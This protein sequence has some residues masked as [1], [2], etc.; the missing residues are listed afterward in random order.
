LVGLGLGRLRTPLAFHLHISPLTSSGRRNRAS[1]ASQPEKRSRLH[2]ATA[3][4][5]TT[6]FREHVVA[7]DQKQNFYC[8]T[9]ILLTWNIWWVSNNA[10][11]WQMGF[12]RVFK[13][14]SPIS[15][16]KVWNTGNADI[17][18]G[19]FRS[20]AHCMFSDLKINLFYKIHLQAFNVISIVLYHSVPTFGK[21]LYSCPPSLL[22]RLI[23]QATS[24]DTSSMLLKHF[25][26]RGF[27]NF[28]NKSKSGGLRS[29]P[30]SRERLPIYHSY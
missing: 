22:M 13:G 17:Y 30:R 26:R 29:C 20:S 5:Q 1:W 19:H 14:L 10:S 12:N 7:L 16:F 11:R 9:L 23:T 18:V 24:S 8:L 3:R 21:V 25:P 4:G 27:F 2:Y 6:K 28:R 15:C